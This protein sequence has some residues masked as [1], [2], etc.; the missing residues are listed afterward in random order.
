MD[1]YPEGMD[2]M[3]GLDGMDMMDDGQMMEMEYGD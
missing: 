2:G 1:D 3:E